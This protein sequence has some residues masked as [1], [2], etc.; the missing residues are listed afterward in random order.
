[1]KK[2]KPYMVYSRCAGSSE[3]AILVFH[4][5]GKDAKKYAWKHSKIID[6][7]CNG[8]YI[9]MA[10]DLIGKECV[11]AQKRQEEPHC[12]DDPETCKVCNLWG[13]PLDEYGCCENCNNGGL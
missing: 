11:Y 3:A 7:I 10:V 13:Y 12:I 5:T 1:M 2:L 9:D 4:Y 6:E 8:E